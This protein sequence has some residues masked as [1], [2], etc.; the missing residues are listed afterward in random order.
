VQITARDN[1][2]QREDF[3]YIQCDLASLE[4]VREF[5]T[6]FRATGRTLDCLVCNAAIYLPTATEPTFTADGYELSV[7]VNH[8]S[9]FLM[10]NELMAD[11]QKSDWKRLI[12]VGSI[13]GTLACRS[14]SVQ[15]VFFLDT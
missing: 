10:A 15:R 11:L 13:T 12:I 4:S 3:T 8:L 7:G 1:G 5:I 6:N 9:H 14:L 2:I